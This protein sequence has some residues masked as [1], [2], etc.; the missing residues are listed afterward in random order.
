MPRRLLEQAEDRLRAPYTPSPQDVFCLVKGYVS[1]ADLAQPPLLVY[2]GCKLDELNQAM[3]ALGE[4]RVPCL[5]E[6][7]LFYSLFLCVMTV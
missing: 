5:L 4:G 2:P 7:C 3:R 1:D 6:I